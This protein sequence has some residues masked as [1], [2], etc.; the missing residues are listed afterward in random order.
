VCA[1]EI[2]TVGHVEVLKGSALPPVV[3]MAGKAI[4][5]ETVSVGAV[6]FTLVT[7]DAIV[8]IRCR[9]AKLVPGDDVAAFALND[10]MRSS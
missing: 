7:G 3:G 1:D 10:C 9:K 4:R 6:V 5:R 2:E 8:L